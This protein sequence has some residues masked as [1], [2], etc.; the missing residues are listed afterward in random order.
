MAYCKSVGGY[1]FEEDEDTITWEAFE[2]RF[3]FK[4]FFGTKKGFIIPIFGQHQNILKR[5]ENQI[6][7]QV[8][9]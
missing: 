2:R 3:E 9:S 1:H 8:C 6:K 5:N 4:F 7:F